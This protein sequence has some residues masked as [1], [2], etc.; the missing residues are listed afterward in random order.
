[1]IFYVTWKFEMFNVFIKLSF[2]IRA[3]WEDNGAGNV[4]LRNFC[5]ILNL[6]SFCIFYYCS[7][8]L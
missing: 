6:H 4:G 3:G 1:M 5:V 2:I 8:I 7:I